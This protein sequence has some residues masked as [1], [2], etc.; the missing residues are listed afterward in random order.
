MIKKLIIIGGLGKGG[1]IDNC[2]ADNQ[3]NFNDFEYEVV[4]YLNDYETNSINGKPVMGGLDSLQ[5][6]LNEDYYFIF[7]IH[8]IGRNYKTESVYNKLNIPAE[9][10][11]TI[12]SKRAFISDSATIQP[13]SVVLPFAYISLNVKIGMSTMIMA[14]TMIGHDTKIGSNCFIGAGSV[15]GSLVDVGN[16]TSICLGS[17]V[18][19]NCKIGSYAVL[20]AGSTLISN[21]ASSKIYVGN[22]AKYLKDITNEE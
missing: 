5:K 15:L 20:G 17:T 21:M 4:G 11:A 6:Y 14:S 16:Y 22:P 19:E 7:G 8:L 13:G 10:L 3:Q 1:P 12:L 9:R 18:I 2:I